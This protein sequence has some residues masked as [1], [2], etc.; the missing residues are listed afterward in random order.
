MVKDSLVGD[1]QPIPRKKNNMSVN[2]PE[3]MPKSERKSSSPNLPSSCSE[4]ELEGDNDIELVG[5]FSTLS[6]SDLGGRDVSFKRRRKKKSNENKMTEK[7]RTTDKK[8]NKTSTT[9]DET[10]KQRRL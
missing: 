8:K 9:V 10:D 2:K 5:S 3:K 6:T 7:K 4:S 1:V